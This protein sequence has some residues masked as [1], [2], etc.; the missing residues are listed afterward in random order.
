M[1]VS[2]RK[3]LVAVVVTFVIAATAVIH[4]RIHLLR[5][6]NQSSLNNIQKVIDR[7]MPEE[8][9]PNDWLDCHVG[10]IEFRLPP[11]LA[12]GMVAPSHGSDLYTFQDSTRSVAVALPKEMSEFSDLLKTASCLDPKSRQFTLPRLR[13]ACYGVSSDDFSWSMTT[14]E[15]RWHTFCVATS[16]LVRFDSDGHTESI[17]RRDFDGIVHFHGKR[18]VFDWQC[19]GRLYGGYMHFVGCGEN[20]DPAWV[21]AVCQSLRISLGQTRGHH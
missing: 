14:E 10:C 4:Y 16:K 12:R 17:F 11:I 20:I 13:L 19:T 7:P 2:R 6:E 5:W 9:T 3:I 1:P 8:S 18:A 15:V 21:R